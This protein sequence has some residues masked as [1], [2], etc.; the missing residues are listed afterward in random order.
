MFEFLIRLH[1]ETSEEEEV[2]PFIRTLLHF[3]TREFLN[4]LALVSF[5]QTIPPAPQVQTLL[6]LVPQTAQR[7]NHNQSKH[8]RQIAPQNSGAIRAA[9]TFFFLLSFSKLYSKDDLERYVDLNCSE[10]RI[11][12]FSTNK[13]VKSFLLLLLFLGLA[14]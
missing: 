1:S 14:G 10:Y 7:I 5:S 9:P 13:I 3:D 6:L 12:N 11:H 2:F 4:V 8:S